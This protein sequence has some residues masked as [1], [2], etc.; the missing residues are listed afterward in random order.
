MTTITS[1]TTSILHSQ[2]KQYT[3]KHKTTGKQHIIE[4]QTPN[5]SIQKQ[6]QPYK[7]ITISQT[8]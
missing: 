3:R 2:N 8:Q 4:I 5:N 6:Q 7:R 1:I